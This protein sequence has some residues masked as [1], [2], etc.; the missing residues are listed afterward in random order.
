[1]PGVC[2]EYTYHDRCFQGESFK[3][4]THSQCILRPTPYRILL[5]FNS[6]GFQSPGSSVLRICQVSVRVMLTFC[7]PPSSDSFQRS[8]TN[9]LLSEICPISI[10]FSCYWFLQKFYQ[11]YK[12]RNFI[13]N[14]LHWIS[15]SIRIIFTNFWLLPKVQWL[16]DM[17]LSWLTWKKQ[18]Q[19]QFQFHEMEENSMW[20]IIV[21]MVLY[22]VTIAWYDAMNLLSFIPTKTT[23]KEE[24]IQSRQ[25]G[26]TCV[27]MNCTVRR[28]AD[29]KRIDKILSKYANQGRWPC[30]YNKFRMYLHFN[31]KP[32]TAFCLGKKEMC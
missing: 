9:P 10:Y 6:D 4:Y 31:V 3:R 11:L 2:L 32:G 24:G 5:S 18:S 16:E 12:C 7:F 26:R 27:N 1:M 30:R 20:L 13:L 8:K 17:C 22:N 25:W 29:T 23:E 28:D 21:I 14:S 19:Y 15:V